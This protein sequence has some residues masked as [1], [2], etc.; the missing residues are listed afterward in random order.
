MISIK[1]FSCGS[2]SQATV[3]KSFSSVTYQNTSLKL[4]CS[5]YLMGLSSTIYGWDKGLYIFF[6]A[7][8]RS[9]FLS[10]ILEGRVFFILAPLTCLAI[11]LRREG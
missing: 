7:Y 9:F 5:R 2:E 3:E 6:S 1:L 10:T 8:V 11:T 4:D